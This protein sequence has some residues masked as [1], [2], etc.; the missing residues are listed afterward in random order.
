MATAQFLEV[1]STDNVEESDIQEIPEL[2]GAASPVNARG[3]GISGEAAINAL[4]LYREKEK[5][6]RRKQRQRIKD[7]IESLRRMSDI[8]SLQLKNL[9][10]SKEVKHSASSHQ[11]SI[12]KEI[13]LVQREERQRSEAEQRRL[14]MMANTQ[15][16]YID[17]LRGLLHLRQKPARLHI[18]MKDSKASDTMEPPLEMSDL[19]LFTSLLQKIDACYARFDD[20][21]NRTG[22]STMPLGEVNTTHWCNESGELEYHQKLHKFAHPLSVDKAL[23]AIWKAFEF[24]LH[25]RDRQIYDG[26]GHPNTTFAMRHRLVRTLASGT[27]VSVIQRRVIRRF[28][29]EDRVVCIWKVY[30]EGEGI[31]R[32]MHSTLTG[33]GSVRALPDE[34]GTQAEVCIRQFPVLMNAAPSVTSEFHKFLRMTLDEDKNSVMTTIQ[35]RPRIEHP[36]ISKC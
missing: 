7:E 17:N 12:W 26:L 30:T 3:G 24:E 2:R 21:M 8:L 29:E 4:K 34:P 18:N 14:T 9:Q 20:V 31:F 23:A 28:C 13:A 6:R 25:Q 32:G 10:L 15:A 1:Y 27:P 33:W 11:F 5:L 35:H 22:L 36:D 19:P 16:A